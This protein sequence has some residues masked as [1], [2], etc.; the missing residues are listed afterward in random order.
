MN[1]TLGSVVPL[2]MF[3][4]FMIPKIWK[5]VV[6]LICVSIR[7]AWTP[8]PE[9]PIV[10]MGFIRPQSSSRSATDDTGNT[11]DTG[12]TCTINNTCIT[13]YT[14]VT[15]NDQDLVEVDSFCIQ[16]TTLILFLRRF[17]AVVLSSFLWV[18]LLLLLIWG[19]AGRVF[20][21]LTVWT[22]RT[23][24]AHSIKQTGSS[25]C[26][27]EEDLDEYGLS[28]LKVIQEF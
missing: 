24:V 25:W 9:Y 16:N 5:H 21:A 7:L 12:N 8:L 20:E 28:S 6:S 19:P 17:F 15:R 3:L 13:S 1:S 4:Q 11:S 14:R 18:L 2:A 26:I 22:A 23:I 10:I 27:D